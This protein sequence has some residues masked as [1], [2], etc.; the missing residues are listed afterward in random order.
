M[1]ALRALDAVP[2]RLVEISVGFP[3][4]PRGG[5]RQRREPRPEE[6]GLIA[7][8][9]V[10]RRARR[11]REP[12][13][14]TRPLVYGPKLENVAETSKS[15]ASALHAREKK[16]ISTR[17][18]SAQAAD[19]GAPLASGEPLTISSTFDL[20]DEEEA[21]ASLGN[22]GRVIDENATTSLVVVAVPESLGCLSLRGDVLAETLC[23]GSNEQGVSH[24]PAD[25]AAARDAGWA[26]DFVVD[27]PLDDGSSYA[28][29]APGYA[30][31]DLDVGGSPFLLKL[32]DGRCLKGVAPADCDHGDPDQ[33]WV[34]GG[35]G[36]VLAY[37]SSADA[38]CLAISDERPVLESCV[39]DRTFADLGT[40]PASWGDA[41]II[42]EMDPAL[43]WAVDDDDIYIDDCG[44]A[45]NSTSSTFSFDG[46]S[47]V[48]VA[49]GL[50]VDAPAMK[51]DA[52]LS[53]APCDG[54]ASQIWRPDDDVGWRQGHVDG[55]C[56][57]AEG[58]AR[59]GTRVQLLQR[60]ARA[61]RPSRFRLF[62]ASVK[63]R[64]R[65]SKDAVAEDATPGSESVVV[66]SARA[67]E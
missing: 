49:S 27:V 36:L 56:A 54:A 19:A 39:L 29:F 44:V 2:G 23:V 37:T 53:V 18:V 11:G 38:S 8:R 16:C 47:V 43:C 3:R 12:A 41:L 40:F 46:G 60:G 35:P 55:L 4:R 13:R 1:R 42:P 21:L 9:R 48:H 20:F 45:G 17:L 63:R 33:I 30:R 50:C 14:G 28:A 61:A 65:P 6:A 32:V 52:Y 24:I 22:G 51:R 10:G 25:A 58:G 59:V 31:A 34:R 7:R 26:A 57:N 15:S 5:G 62:A 66:S 67:R 64:R